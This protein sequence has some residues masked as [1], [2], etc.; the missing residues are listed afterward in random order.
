VPGKVGGSLSVGQIS[1]KD[2]RV[3]AGVIYRTSHL[4][5]PGFRHDQEALR[6]HLAL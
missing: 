2:L 1:G 4:L 3:S 6:L 5:G